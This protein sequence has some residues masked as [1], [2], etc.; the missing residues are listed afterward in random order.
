M[1]FVPNASLDRKQ[2]GNS[3]EC[4]PHELEGASVLAGKNM[5]N[6]RKFKKM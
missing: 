6:G 5:Y 3:E 2:G 1:N 4:V